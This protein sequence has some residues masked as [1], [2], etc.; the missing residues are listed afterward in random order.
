MKVYE[1]LRWASSF[2]R[3][4]GRDE[5]A[6]EWLLMNQLGL[7][8]AQMLANM[9]DE[10]TEEEEAIFIKD[11]KKHGIEAVPVQHIIGSEEFY[12]RTFLVNGDVLIPRPETEE[13]IFHALAKL[14]KLFNPEEKL[15]M[16]DI[17]TGSG[18]IAITMALECPG[19]K[20]TAVDL[21]EKALKQAAENAQRLQAEVAFLQGDLLKPLIDAGKRVNVLLSNPPY[22]PESDHA[23]LSDVVKNHEPHL[24]LFAGNDGLDCYRQITSDLP[25]VLADKA[26]VG[27]EVGAGQG[28]QVAELMQA[29]YPEAH[30]EVLFDINGKD[31]MVFGEIKS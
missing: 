11:V 8:R 19:M 20:V 14:K 24:A 29:V 6:G 15:D 13:L 16:A 5:N 21:S 9:H 2:L 27:F 4:N 22:I 12:G 26:L 31:R 17:G 18:I 3:E 10:L 30:V 25:S 7:S 23:I 28:E 1:A